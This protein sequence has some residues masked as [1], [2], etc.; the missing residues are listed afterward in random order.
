MLRA[1]ARA[2]DIIFCSS[3]K[4]KIATNMERNA[5]KSRLKKMSPLVL[6]AL[7]TVSARPCCHHSRPA[8]AP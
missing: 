6:L 8:R 2:F 7:T 5:V 4:V 3:G 1:A